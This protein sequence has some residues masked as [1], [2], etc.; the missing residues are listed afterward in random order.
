[1][2]DDLE[3]LVRSDADNWVTQVFEH[4]RNQCSNCGNDDR[5]RVKLAV[6]EEA[7]GQRVLS[8]AFLIC[9][10]CEMASEIVNRSTSPASGQTTRP[11]NF[12]ISRTLYDHVQNGLARKYGFKSVSSLVRFLMSK[13]VVDS[14]LFDD[15]G[16]YQDDGADVKVNV[17]VSRVTYETFKS[18]TDKNGLTV[19]GALKGLMRMYE[20]E[21]DRVTGRTET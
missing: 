10:P 18:L 12:W 17:W 13:Y 4:C 15:I 6:P 14:G 8:N 21:A 20:I 16:R 2:A 5:L 7:G 3:L 11:I 1:M 19:T 9:R